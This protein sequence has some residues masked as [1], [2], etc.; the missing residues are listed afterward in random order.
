M[1]LD[2]ND[3]F[4]AASNSSIETDE[5]TNDGNGAVIGAFHMRQS[6]AKRIYQRNVFNCLPVDGK[7]MPQKVFGA[8][9]R[10][11]ATA[12]LLPEN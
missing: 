7:R 6:F 4:L 3:E 10:I 12:F 8:A 5:F 11:F 9:L 2:A 1:K